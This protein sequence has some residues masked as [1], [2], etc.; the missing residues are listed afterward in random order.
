MDRLTDDIN[1]NCKKITTKLTIIY[2][3][4]SYTQTKITDHLY[5]IIMNSQTMKTNH[6]FTDLRF[7][8]VKKLQYKLILKIYLTIKFRYIN[9][10][11]KLY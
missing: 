8:H 2:T 4:F 6:A 10:Y 11:K 3:Q 7:T 9:R 1:I 5:K